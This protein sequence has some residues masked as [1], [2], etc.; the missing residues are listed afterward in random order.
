VQGIVHGG[1]SGAPGGVRGGDSPPVFLEKGQK[2]MLAWHTFDGV[3]RISPPIVTIG[4]AGGLF[5]NGT[6]KNGAYGCTP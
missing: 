3:N 4:E 5:E 2:E 1:G 6:C